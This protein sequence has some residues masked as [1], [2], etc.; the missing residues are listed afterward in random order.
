[1]DASDRS[2]LVRPGDRGQLAP[3]RDGRRGLPGSAHA[4]TNSIYESGANPRRSDAASGH[5]PA[6]LP[7]SRSHGTARLAKSA[8]GLRARAAL[9]EAE[10]EF[11]SI[12]ITD[13]LYS[14]AYD[15][16][17][18]RRSHRLSEHSHGLAIDVDVFAIGK[19]TNT[20][21]LETVR[22]TTSRVACSE[23]S[24][25]DCRRAGSFGSFLR[26]RTTGTITTIS[27][28]KRSLAL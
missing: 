28:W 17:T 27:T 6:A 1:M 8:H 7:A 4:R 2:S 22:S 21:W 20:T 14:E 19:G 16:R 18:R 13:L 12:G 25:R 23:L 24:H 10:P 26:L 15:Y 3:Y 9:F 5:R 11:A